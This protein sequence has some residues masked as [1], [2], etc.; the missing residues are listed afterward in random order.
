MFQPEQLQNGKGRLNQRKFY[1][2]I[3]RENAFSANTSCF[4]SGVRE[5]L[6]GM[7]HIVMVTDGVV[8]CG[9]RTFD[10]DQFYMK[11]YMR[12]INFK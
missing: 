7:N 4:T 6:N 3:G 5:L 2:C 11:H 10:D 12:K 1:E 9:R 8:E